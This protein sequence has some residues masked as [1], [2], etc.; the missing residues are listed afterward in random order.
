M[1]GAIKE[2]PNAKDYLNRPDKYAN[3]WLDENMPVYGFTV[4]DLDLVLRWYDKDK[5]PYGEFMLIEVKSGNS[6]LGKNQYMNYRNFDRLFK[7]GD[8]V[9]NPRR[10]RYLGFYLIWSELPTWYVM[11]TDNKFAINHVPVTYAQLDAF[12]HREIYSKP[13]IKPFEFTGSYEQ[14]HERTAQLRSG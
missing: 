13:T 12:M 14:Y 1:Y 5:D 10:A 6:T 2:P 7:A 8:L 3:K 9:H 4:M 11:A